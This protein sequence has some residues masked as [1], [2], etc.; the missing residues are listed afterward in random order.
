MNQKSYRLITIGIAGTIALITLLGYFENKRDKALK[1]EI[2]ELDKHIKLLD[3]DHKL[4]T[5]TKK[6]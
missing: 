6:A 5:A 2:M 1:A 4:H 3:L